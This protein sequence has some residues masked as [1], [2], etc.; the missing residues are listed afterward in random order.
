MGFDPPETSSDLVGVRG[1]PR[2]RSLLVS[3]RSL[4]RT[5]DGESLRD[6]QDFSGRSLLGDFLGPSAL[7][8]TSLTGSV[9]VNVPY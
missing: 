6:G 7:T 4:S 1:L 3:T 8:D 9:T 5:R 2:I